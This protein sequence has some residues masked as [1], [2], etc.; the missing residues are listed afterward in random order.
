MATLPSTA[1]TPVDAANL[2]G[3]VAPVTD[4]S[5]LGMFMQAD[6]AVKMVIIML[7][8]AS[9]WSWKIIFEKLMVFSNVRSKAAR[10]EQEFW[11]SDALDKLHE[12]TKKRPTHPMA[13][14][15]TAAM[16][17]WFRSKGAPISPV[18]QTSIRAGLRERVAQVMRVSVNREL[19]RLEK[20]VN[21]LATV[22]SAS[23]FIGLFGTVLGIMNSFHNIAA[24]KNTSLVSVAP[25]IAEALFATAIG[26]FAAIPANIAY[27][28]FS[29]ELAL[30]SGKFDDFCIEFDTI[31]SRQLGQ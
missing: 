27:N 19:E 8:V 22:S 1:T 30:L 29:K 11:A 5:M 7:V 23:P 3:T 10:F 31:L 9:I 24:T 28:R 4:L 20:G 18:A 14:I 26:L 21:F 17:E 13:T 6:I 2:A 25:G 15:F 16:D 12:R